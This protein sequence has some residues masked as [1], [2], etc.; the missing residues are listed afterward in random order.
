M[1]FGGY[2]NTDFIK[3]NYSLLKASKTVK[4]RSLGNK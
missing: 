3:K 1:A 4:Q 2:F